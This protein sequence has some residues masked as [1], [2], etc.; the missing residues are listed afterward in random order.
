[1]LK[2]S[3]T[4]PVSLFFLAS[5][6]A[7]PIS[8]LFSTPQEPAFCACEDGSGKY[9]A[10]GEKCGE[11]TEERVGKQGYYGELEISKRPAYYFKDCRNEP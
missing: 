8:G 7:N 5:C 4:L 9:G 3:I 11:V 10:K 2:K 6:S 1:M